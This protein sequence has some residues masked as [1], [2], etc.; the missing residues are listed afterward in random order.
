M[1]GREIV[2][3]EVRMR[4]REREREKKKS[5]SF[6]ITGERAEK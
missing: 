6:K 3:G 2:K 5:K 1:A 4:E